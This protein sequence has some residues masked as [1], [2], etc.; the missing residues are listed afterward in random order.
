MRAKIRTLVGA[1]EGH[2][3]GMRQTFPVLTRCSENGAELWCGIQIVSKGPVTPGSAPR[4]G[5]VRHFSLRPPPT[6]LTPLRYLP[7]PGERR[8]GG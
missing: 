7:Q 2:G 1:T 6:R 3:M 5:V 4:C 8:P